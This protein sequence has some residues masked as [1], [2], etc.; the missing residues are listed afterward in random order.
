M[1]KSQY[2][3]LSSIEDKYKKEENVR[4]KENGVRNESEGKRIIFCMQIGLAILEK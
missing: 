1:H 2:N 4:Q 3:V